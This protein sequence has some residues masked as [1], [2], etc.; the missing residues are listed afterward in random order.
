MLKRTNRDASLL[1]KEISDTVMWGR[2]RLVPRRTCVILSS[3]LSFEPLLVSA[4]SGLFT[5][6]A[7]CVLSGCP[8]SRGA[9]G[10]LTDWRI[11]MSP[12][13]LGSNLCSLKSNAEQL[14]SSV[15]WKLWTQE[16]G[17]VAIIL[18]GK[19]AEWAIDS[20]ASLTCNHA[21]IVV[22]IINRKY[23][24]SPLTFYFTNILST[25]HLIHNS[26]WN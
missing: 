16:D 17:T 23:Q 26:P 8:T 18:K 15:I 24:S 20:K 1:R 9:T 7:C 5:S 21:P 25:I 13:I 4:I 10:Y 22:S 14:P 12:E 3:L 11:D 19:F 2:F 6:F